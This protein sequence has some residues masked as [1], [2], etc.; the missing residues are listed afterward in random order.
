MF[1]WVLQLSQEKSKTMFMHFFCGRGGGGINRVIM[2]YVK[3]GVFLA[4][5]ETIVG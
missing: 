5:A 2:V 1:F 4:V 3:M